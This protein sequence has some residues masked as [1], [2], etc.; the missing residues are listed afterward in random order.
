MVDRKGVTLEFAES[1]VVQFSG[2]AL[3]FENA[4]GADLLFYPG[5]ALIARADGVFALVDLKELQV[6]FEPVTF[7]EDETVPPDAQVMGHTWAKVNRDGSPDRRFRDNYQIP[8]CRYGKLFI[9]STT[10]VAEEYQFSN[11]IAAERFARAFGLYRQ[12]L[13]S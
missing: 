11:V 1:D 8:L 3:A 13:S 2:R 6:A 9:A 4:N 12:A 10:G 5:I 7:V